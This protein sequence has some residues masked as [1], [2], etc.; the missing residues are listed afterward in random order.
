MCHSFHVIDEFIAKA[1]GT[2]Q[3]ASRALFSAVWLLHSAARPSAD[4]LRRCTFLSVIKYENWASINCWSKGHKFCPR[5]A[6]QF[7]LFMQSHGKI[8]SLRQTSAIPLSMTFGHNHNIEIR[9]LKRLTWEGGMETLFRASMWQ[10]LINFLV[11]LERWL[12]GEPLITLF[13]AVAGPE[14][15]WEN[16]RLELYLGHFGRLLTTAYDDD[17]TPDTLTL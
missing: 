6:A 9:T 2:I 7:F 4:E 1:T 15:K 14:P 17:L 11:R 3:F 16:F 13:A 8:I 12:I 10:K 5:I